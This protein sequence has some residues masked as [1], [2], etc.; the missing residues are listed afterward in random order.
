MSA[1]LSVSVLRDV[2]CI[3]TN[4]ATDCPRRLCVFFRQAVQHQLR[5]CTAS[6]H[7]VAALC[8][9]NDPVNSPLAAKEQAALFFRLKKRV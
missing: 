6:L 2:E 7:C 1:V 3:D 4:T 8:T 5:R 9:V